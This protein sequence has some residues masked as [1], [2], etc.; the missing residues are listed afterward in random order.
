M[1]QICVLVQNVKTSM[2]DGRTYGSQVLAFNEITKFHNYV[3]KLYST[4]WYTVVEEKLYYHGYFHN[5]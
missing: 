4:V 3:F 2:T 5:V 1:K